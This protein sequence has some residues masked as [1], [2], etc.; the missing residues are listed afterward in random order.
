VNDDLER[1]VDE[2]KRLIAEARAA[3]A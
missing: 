3:G 2:V 1:T